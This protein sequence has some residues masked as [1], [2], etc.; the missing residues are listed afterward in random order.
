MSDST[1]KIKDKIG[2]IALR[3]R[4]GL[5]MEMELVFG[6]LF[7]SCG[8]RHRPRWLHALVADEQFDVAELII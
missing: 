8:R 6:S 3:E 5:L 4:A 2:V 1:E 7:F